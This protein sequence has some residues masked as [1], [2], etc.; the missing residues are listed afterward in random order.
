MH[1]SI[2]KDL[3]IIVVC[4]KLTQW[5]QIENSETQLVMI[6]HQDHPF[7]LYTTIKCNQQAKQAK[8]IHIFLT[9]HLDFI[10]FSKNSATVRNF[11]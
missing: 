1:N 7:H 11:N 3:M 9:I 4:R 2:R 8:F 6:G 10:H 5:I